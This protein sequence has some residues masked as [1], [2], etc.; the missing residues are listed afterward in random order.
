M[1]GTWMYSLRLGMDGNWGASPHSSGGGGLGGI[2][3]PIA[4][5]GG[6]TLWGG[7][8]TVGRDG[9][10]RMPQPHS[11]DGWGGG[12][13]SAWSVVGLEGE[14]R[15][16]R[17]AVGHRGRGASAPTPPELRPRSS[18]R[19]CPR[20]C[21]PTSPC[22]CTRSCCSF[23]SLGGPAGAACAPS[24]WGC[25]PLSAHPASS[26]SDGATRS[27]R[28]TSSAPAPWRC[29]GTAPSSPSS[30]RDTGVG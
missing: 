30:V 10:L 20:S 18:C 3:S 16:A 21:G 17:G 23:P 12:A 8:S 25:A 13:L 22:T 19:A 24:P 11:R 27:R 14:L 7:Q 29:C 4:G 2:P 9:E 6:G 15:G 28:S 5:M 26:S 1:G